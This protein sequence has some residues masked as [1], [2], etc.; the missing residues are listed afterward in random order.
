MTRP[1]PASLILLWLTLIVA[2]GV[3]N[4]LPLVLSGLA[5][6]V[7]A[8]VVAPMHLHRLLR[9]SRWLLLTLFMLF[10]WMTPG[11]PLGSVPGMSVEGL[12]LA[13]EHVIRLLL[14]LAA[15]ALILQVLSPVE[16]VA[17]MRSLLAPLALFGLS[18]D[19]IAVRLAL[20]L[21]EVERARGA[22]SVTGD[23]LHLPQAGF[24]ASDVLLG[25]A[26]AI[27]AGTV[28]LS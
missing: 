1:C 7:L 17:G 16:L 18:R 24:G 10:S 5:L 9:R 2:A 13:A 27:L 4:G 8:F 6:V 12:Q 14:A 11:T 3:R 23:V 22:I 28:W 20:T 25:L 15:L 19:R 21:E 26:T